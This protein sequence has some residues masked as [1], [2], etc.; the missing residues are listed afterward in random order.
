MNEDRI[1]SLCVSVVTRSGNPHLYRIADVKE[2]SLVPFEIDTTRE[3][4]H[5][6]INL[7]FHP[8]KAIPGEGTVGFWDWKSVWESDRY[9]PYSYPNNTMR[10]IEYVH[11]DE[12]TNIHS[13]K[14]LLLTGIDRIDASHDYL[15]EFERVND[16]ERAC[17][18]CKG[19]DF[20]IST[21]L[22]KK[23]TLKNDVYN[24]NVYII[25]I[26][27]VGQFHTRYL[28]GFSFNYYKKLSLGECE[29]TEITRIPEAIVRDVILS[30]IKKYTPDLSKS[31]RATIRRFLGFISNNSLEE[32]IAATCKCDI[33]TARA[34]L[35][36]FVQ[37]CETYF[38]CD[39]FDAQ[40][41]TR[42]IESNSKI[43]ETF[44]NMVQKS[45]ELEN[46]LSL[47]K[48]NEDLSKVKIQ[49]MN[50]SDNLAKIQADC[51]VLNQTKSDLETKI[52]ELHQ[53]YAQ[54]LQTA[55]SI[56]SQV[57]EKIK[58]AEGDAASFFAEYVLFTSNGSAASA[59][60][61][62]IDIIFGQ[63][64]Y[65]DPGRIKSVSELYDCLKENLNIAGVGKERCSAL[66]AYLLAAYAARTPLI[67][68]G[69]GADALLDA[70]SATMAN[71]TAHRV[72][73]SQ[74]FSIDLIAKIPRAEIVAVHDA[75]QGGA[76]DRLSSPTLSPYTCFVSLTSEELAIEPRGIYN[77]A[78]PLFT[79]YFIEA[80]TDG[81]FEGYVCNVK[82]EK[83]LGV[84]YVSLPE[85]ILSPFALGRC[86]ELAGIAAGIANSNI[87]VFDL[88]L[89]QTM[90]IM[91][92]LGHREALLEL[93]S[94]S[95]LSDKE[96]KQI[97]TLMGEPQ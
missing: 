67:F 30:H 7:I 53:K 4:N 43:A 27:D 23:A 93:I 56:V 14:K 2:D 8:A 36:E 35:N 19:L 47:Q 1:T 61:T 95:S 97:F 83:K 16:T 64:I 33:Q 32:S 46:I 17:I 91:L 77:Y 42:L 63:K 12:V 72:Y 78:L 20:N 22:N 24:L 82:P 59:S 66:A 62:N 89:L 48:A 94:A 74:E 13:L 81:E 80:V 3:Q 37:N 68:A 73:Y 88:F 84:N 75:F 58:I 41:L 50:E 55:E 90:P 39:D 40:L 34:Y 54:Q 49:I 79:E 6:N 92:S 71:K 60:K 45:W 76:I 28:P 51:A 15:F 69:Y 96:K 52:T 31:E 25:S 10:W 44:Q 21:G 11:I 87:S 70:L 18:Y 57:R 65:D 29:H 38:N 26:K 86:K 85:H 9:K 5:Y